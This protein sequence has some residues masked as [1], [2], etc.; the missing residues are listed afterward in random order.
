MLK[1]QEYLLN[2]NSLIDL[3]RKYNIQCNINSELNLVSLNYTNLSPMDEEIVRECRGLFLEL[4][5]FNVVCKSFTA[6]PDQSEI[7]TTKIFN[8]NNAKLIEKLDGALICLYYYKEEWRI[9]MRMSVDGSM[10]VTAINGVPTPLSFAELTKNTIEEMGY[11]WDEYTSKL[12]KNIYY[13]LELV[14]PETRFGV[15]YFNRKLVLIGALNNFDFSEVDIFSLDF[16]KEKPTY[17]IV[18]NEQEVKDLI[19][20][21]NDP[22]RYE[23]F[24]LCDDQFNRVKYK[25]PYFVEMMSE[26]VTDNE[27]SELEQ[28]LNYVTTFSTGII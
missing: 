26:G 22:L 18:Q 7:D 6:F 27:L 14:G 20:K 17:Y 4:E 13:S 1:V 28:L 3:S 10:Q 25:N 2:G 16:P 11:T 19:D 21:Y 5:T 8:W 23:G 12:D 24:V 9:G 15:L